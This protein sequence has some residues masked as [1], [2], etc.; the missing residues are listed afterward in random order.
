MKQTESNEAKQGPPTKGP[1][2]PWKPPHEKEEEAAS[3][4]PPAVPRYHN[5][6]PR[7]ALLADLG[8]KEKTACSSQAAQFPQK[9][10][11]WCLC[12]KRLKPTIPRSHDL[13]KNVCGSGSQELGKQRHPYEDRVPDVSALNVPSRRKKML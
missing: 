10:I 12:P 13:T 5:I 11:A 7:H 4:L 2:K 3:S 6:V 1:Y 8:G 9:V